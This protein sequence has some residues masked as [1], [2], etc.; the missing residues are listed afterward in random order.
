[1]AIET[2]LGSGNVS[3]RAYGSSAPFARIGNCEQLS[4]NI[5][6]NEISLADHTSPGGGKY[7]SVRRIE[8]VEIA[9]SW[10]E[11]SVS[12]LVKVL[13]ATSTYLKPE[14]VAGEKHKAAPGG[15]IV[16]DRMP[17]TITTVKNGASELKA[18][19]GA[20]VATGGG[21][22]IPEDSALPA[23]TELTIAYQGAGV[24]V[25][26]ALTDSG[27][28]YEMFFEGMNE[29]GT[30][31][32]ANIRIHRVKIGAAQDL[33]WIGDDF[34]ALDVTAESLKDTTRGGVGKSAYFRIEKERAAA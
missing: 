22:L 27:Q 28:V 20:Y 18:D 15:L 10:N 2:W 23:D 34:A 26:E 11:L 7:D 31:K 32:R 12:N 24:D 6:E 30:G 1:M 19:D 5:N 13:Y 14:A 3:L 4:F 25:I 16:L 21:I 33:N 9:M 29:A 17:L 8:S